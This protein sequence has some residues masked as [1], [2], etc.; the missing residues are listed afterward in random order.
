MI[1]SFATQGT[2]DI[3][4]GDN[5]KAARKTLPRDLWDIA[6][7]KF[8]LLNAAGAVKDLAIPPANCLEKLKG[9]LKG[10]YSIRINDQYR[11]VFT[12]EGGDA[13]DVEVMDYH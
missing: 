10:K 11:I 12:F 5:T 4:N 13:S 6:W 2:E 8:A 7:R 3:Y 9:N 1:Q